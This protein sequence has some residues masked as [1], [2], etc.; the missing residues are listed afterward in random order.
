MAAMSLWLASGAAHAQDITPR[1]ITL[2]A[3]QSTRYM[4]LS[5]NHYERLEQLE[6]CLE[7]D[8]FDTCL[9]THNERWRVRVRRVGASETFQQRFNP[10]GESRLYFTCEGRFH[11]NYFL[12]LTDK[13]PNR[14]A[15]TIRCPPV[16]PLGAKSMTE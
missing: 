13:Y 10:H 5:S 14:A 11:Q 4:L 16:A 12:E 9:S 15:E 7:E 2:N 6:S 3:P 1:V 8:G